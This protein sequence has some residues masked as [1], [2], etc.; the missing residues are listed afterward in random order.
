VPYHIDE[1][2]KG[3]CV[4]KDDTGETVKCHDTHEEAVDH[5]Q[6]LYASEEKSVTVVTYGGVVK[7]LPDNKVGGYLVTFGGLD[8]TGDYFDKD[9]D[10]GEYSRLP[11]LYHHGFDEKMKTRRIGTAEVKQDDLGLWAEAQ[12]NMRDE[13]EK[14]VYEMVQNGKLGWSSGAA[15]HVVNKEENEKGSHITQWYMAEASLTPCPAEPRNSVI[16]LKAFLGVSD[17]KPEAEAAQSAQKVEVIQPKGVNIMEITDEKLQEITDKAAQSAVKAFVAAQPSEQEPD[18]EV[19]TD[20]ADNALK[21]GWKHPGEF[22]M[23]VKSAALRPYEIDKRLL[24][25]KANGLNESIPSQGGF[26]VEQ[27]T[28]PGIFERMYSQGTVLSQFAVDS[29][30]PNSNGMVYNTVD[31][32][33]RAEGSRWGGL[34]GYW[35]NEGGTKTASQPVFSQVNL[36]LKKIAAL[37]YATDE[38]LEDSRALESWI[39]R[40]VPDELRFMIEDAILNGNGAGKPLGML[41][42]AAFIEE[43]PASAAATAIVAGDLA[44]M[45][46]RRWV[47][48]KDYIW[49]VDQSVLP[50]LMGL[51][52]GNFPVYMPPNGIQGTPAA[53]LFG[54]PVFEVEYL[55]DVNVA[56]GPIGLL[57]CAPSQYA[58]IDKG[59][60]QSAKSLEVG[61]LT[62]ESVFRFVYRIDGAPMWHTALTPHSGGET[63]SPFIALGSTS[64]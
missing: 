56:T 27:T 54:R 33:S 31:E 47:G 36:K 53:M 25:L 35:M 13:Y 12:L 30:G 1:D 24:P 62:D 26:L 18:I 15:A 20:E 51:T 37:C 8:M 28:A 17:Q 52:I 21:G 55:A 40:T 7:A 48:A 49:L 64:S 60:V 41:Q 42:S 46:A 14:M 44:A 39:T 2:G 22:Y 23:A 5:M 9:T 32:S 34:Q 4:I 29:I 3:K 59:G 45:W 38:L 19:V 57:L 43:P 11:V 16:P 50:S 6:A 63:V 61:F 10:F 58:L